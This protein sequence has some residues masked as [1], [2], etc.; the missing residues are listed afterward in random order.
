[1]IDSIKSYDSSIKI[2]WNEPLMLFDSG[3]TKTAKYE[4][5][6]FVKSLKEHF[7]GSE[8]NDIYFCPVYMNIDSFGDFK[9]TISTVDEFNQDSSMKVTDTTH[10]NNFGY[11]TLAKATY[12]FMENI[13]E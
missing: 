8:E 2:I 4:R 5:L 12:A 10:P 13:A 7:E 11:E 3:T 6:A 1:M 9:F